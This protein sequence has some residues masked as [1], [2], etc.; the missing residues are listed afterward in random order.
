MSAQSAAKFRKDYRAAG[1]YHLTV[2][3]PD[4]VRRQLASLSTHHRLD[5]K[6]VLIRLIMGEPLSGRGCTR[7]QQLGMS[8]EEFQAYQAGGGQ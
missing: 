7:Q 4:Q 8:D 6:E 1:G 5:R 3:V 2:F